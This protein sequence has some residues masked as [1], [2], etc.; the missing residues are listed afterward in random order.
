M[1]QR[2]TDITKTLLEVVEELNLKVPDEVIFSEA[3]TTFRGEEMNKNKSF[4]KKDYNKNE[5]ITQSQLDFIEK[6]KHNLIAKGFVINDIQYKSQ[7]NKIISEYIKLIKEVK[8]G[9]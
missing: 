9:K 8:N 1:K 5:P 4:Y 7:A 3:L 2:I 6:N